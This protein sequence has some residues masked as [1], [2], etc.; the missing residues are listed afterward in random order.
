MR[1]GNWRIVGDGP[2]EEVGMGG[3]DGLRAAN[4]EQLT[5]ST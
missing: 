3:R 2:V 5:S 1:N 4:R